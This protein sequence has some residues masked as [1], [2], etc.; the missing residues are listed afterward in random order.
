MATKKTEATNT[1]PEVVVGEPCP[2]CGQTVRTPKLTEDEQR[3]KRREYRNRPEVKERQREYN[4]QR[5][6][7]LKELRELQRKLEAEAETQEA[8]S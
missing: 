8:Q 3:D 1:T 4:K 7:E 6:A 5:N 2:R